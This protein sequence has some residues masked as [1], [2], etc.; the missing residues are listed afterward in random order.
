MLPAFILEYTDLSA[1]VCLLGA[2]GDSHFRGFIGSGSSGFS[3]PFGEMLRSFDGAGW[4]TSPNVSILGLARS[5]HQ[6]AQISTR[7]HAFEPV[8]GLGGWIRERASINDHDG[9]LDVTQATAD[10]S[11]AIL[12]SDIDYIKNTQGKLIIPAHGAGANGWASGWYG[13]FTSHEADERAYV[14]ANRVAY[15]NSTILNADG[16]YKAGQFGADGT[17]PNMTGYANWS[18][19][20]WTA[21]QSA[22]SDYGVSV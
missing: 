20:F 10:A 1:D 4:A 13:R 14:G 22:L 21:I 18:G 8:L 17:H 15:T 12:Q 19:P 3:G 11:W 7:L 6:Q 16:S 9:S 2:I 5:G